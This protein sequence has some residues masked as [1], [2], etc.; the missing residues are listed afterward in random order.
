MQSDLFFF[1]SLIKPLHIILFLIFNFLF[2]CLFTLAVLG[3]RCCT[4]F[5]LVA[6]SGGSS[7]VAG[8]GRLVGGSLSPGRAQ[9][10][11]QAGS[12]VPAPPL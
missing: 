9:A 2:M 8:R 4:G 1:F 11:V 6:A 7:P 10:R 5:S 12:V 3:L